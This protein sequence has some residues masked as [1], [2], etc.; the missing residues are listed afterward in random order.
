MSS[1]LPIL[2][3]DQKILLIGG[4]K[5]ALQKAEVLAHNEITFRV[6]S[7]E[8]DSAIEVLTDNII[9]KE[10]KLKDIKDED[11]IIDA[12]GN[13]KV[14]QKLLKYKKRHPILLN[15]VDQPQYCD[16]YFMALTKNRPLQIAVSSNG[17]S[18]TA[19]KYF[20]DMCEKMIPEDITAYLKQKQQERDMGFISVP[21]TLK[22]LKSQNAKVYLVGCGIGDPELLTIKAY[23]IIK[24]V[25][26]VLY[27]HLI[28]QEIMAL[29]PK[30]TKK[31]FV[32]KQK[33]YHSK[34]QE[35]I[36]ALI[37][38]YA[39]QGKKIARLKSGDPFVF[40]RGAE[41]LMVLAQQ[42][43]DTEV[44]PGISSSISAPLM[45]DIPVTARGYASGFTVVS[46][47]LKGNRINLDWIDLLQKENHTVVVLMGLSRI[48]EIVHEAQKLGISS[49]KPCAIISNASRPNQKIVTTRLKNL[50]IDGKEMPR[51]AIIVFGD[52]VTFKTQLA[53]VEN[54]QFAASF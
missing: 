41:E 31:V 45:G 42:Y 5:V 36:N 21:K 12:T 39:G 4:G 37:L 51:P 38:H 2:L 9:Q 52:V 26:V 44:V 35:E 43:I 54:E 15:V 16:F 3:K 19:A 46:A 22:E 7:S 47:H 1:T 30:H 25:D 18:P 11:I 10:F 50:E 48:K 32:G 49:N 13:P 6:V 33:G 40:G 53:G 8:I 14:T 27:D 23:K 20:R 29:I 17:A 28:S 34:S 24:D